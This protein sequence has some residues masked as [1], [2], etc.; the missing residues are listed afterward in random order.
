MFRSCF[1]VNFLFYAGP[2]LYGDVH[3]GVVKKVAFTIVLERPELYFRSPV[4]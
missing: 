4:F 2:A 3:F 1:I